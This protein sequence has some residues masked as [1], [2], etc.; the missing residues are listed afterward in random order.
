MKYCDAAIMRLDAIE[1]KLQY[2]LGAS[3]VVNDL[4]NTMLM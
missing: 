4:S 3:I 2:T 1:N